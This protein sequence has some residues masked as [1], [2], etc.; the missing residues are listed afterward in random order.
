MTFKEGAEDFIVD[1]D[2]GL[3]H[4]M[5]RCGYLI[6]S[7]MNQKSG[8]L[9]VARAVGADAVMVSWSAPETFAAAAL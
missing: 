6:L 7:A 8:R 5:T 3:E 1:K 4:W 9:A 2:P